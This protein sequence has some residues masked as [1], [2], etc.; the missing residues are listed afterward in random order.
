MITDG[1]QI[2]IIEDLLVF[3]YK[4]YNSTRTVA[5]PLPEG[6]GKFLS[7]FRVRVVCLS[8]GNVLMH[9][10]LFVK[11]W[12]HKWNFLSEGNFIWKWVNK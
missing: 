6:S 7:I 11:L 8:A 9:L 3:N 1:C 4:R 2:I 10:K 5:E 12:I